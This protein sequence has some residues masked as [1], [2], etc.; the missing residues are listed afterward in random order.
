[1]KYFKII[2]KETGELMCYASCD[3]DVDDICKMFGTDEYTFEEIS[4]EEF[5]R[6]EERMMNNE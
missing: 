1:M 5:E 4:K 3:S 2:H 6:E